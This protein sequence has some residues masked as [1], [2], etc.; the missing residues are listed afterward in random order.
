ML[1]SL[2]IINFYS[3]NLINQPFNLLLR[4]GFGNRYLQ[5]ATW[6]RSDHFICTFDNPHV[7]AFK[8]TDVI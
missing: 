3:K 2:E 6:L 7:I 5:R 1:N 4:F 8:A